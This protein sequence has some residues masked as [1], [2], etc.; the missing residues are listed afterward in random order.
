MS[1][2]ENYFDRHEFVQMTRAENGVLEV[3]LHTEGGSLR[4]GTAAHRCLT[5]AFRDIALDRGNSVVLLTGAG[6]EFLGPR[7]SEAGGQTATPDRNATYWEREAFSDGREM[8]NAILD[9][10]VPVICAVNGPV[11]R[12]C[13][14]ALLSDVIV[15]SETASFEDSAHFHLQNL[16]PGDGIHVVATMLMGANRARAFM[17][18]GNAID[19]AE[20]LRLG[21]VAEVLPQ[22]DVLPRAREIADQIAAKPDI[23]RRFTRALLIQPIRKQMVDLLGMGFAYEGLAAM[24]R[25]DSPE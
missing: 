11:R 22:R 1:S 20:A 6:D 23:A 4:W 13:E 25:N 3:V 10:P 2:V 8:V 16:V 7:A 5:R 15:A 18:T 21:L 9:I 24:G 19:A 12:H 14:T 17:Y